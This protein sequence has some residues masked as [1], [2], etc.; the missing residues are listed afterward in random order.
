VVVAAERQGVP[1]TLCGELG[2]KTLEAMALVGLGLRRLSVSPAA[3]GPVKMM[4]RSLNLAS[5]QY[6]MDDLLTLGDRSLRGRLLD[7]ARDHH[8]AL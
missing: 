8:V 1:V 6:Y 5:L 3:V 4:I 7:F 2:G